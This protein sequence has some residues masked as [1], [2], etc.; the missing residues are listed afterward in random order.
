VTAEFN[1]NVLRVIN[2][3]LQ[4]EFDPDSFEHVAYYNED[5]ER[6]EIYLES[7]Q[8]QKVTIGDLDLEVAFE[9]GERMRTEVSCKY[10]RASVDAILSEAGLALD[11]W[12]TGPDRAFALS[13]ASPSSS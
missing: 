13:L 8:S 1:R 10:T 5:R 2:S 12:F 4:G 11:E 9:A 7:G 6:M 3:R